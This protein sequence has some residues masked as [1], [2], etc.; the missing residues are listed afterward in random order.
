MMDDQL[1]GLIIPAQ[2]TEFNGELWFGGALLLCL[3][4]LAVWR[5][6]K[7]RRS[8]LVIAQKKLQT[9]IQFNAQHPN[10]SHQ[11]SLSL[12]SILCERFAVKRLDQITINTHKDWRVFEKKLNTASYSTDSNTNM[13]ALLDEAKIWIRN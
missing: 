1:Q 10:E 12:V 6:K 7:A 9:L 4:V 3:L 2:E 8:P 13:K 5:W 11:V